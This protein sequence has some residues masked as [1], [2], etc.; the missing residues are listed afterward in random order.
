MHIRL[1]RED[2]IPSLVQLA[3][4]VRAVDRWPPHRVG[5]TREF[6]AGSEPLTALVADDEGVVVG[7]VVLH[8]RSA[9][10]V[11]TV[12]SETLGVERSELAVV[13]RLF[14]AP[15]VRGR[16]VGRALL[17]A[18]VDA[19]TGVDRYPILDV[20]TELD[21]AIGLYQAEG[22]TRLGEVAFTFSSPCSPGC[23]HPG[24]SLRSF[25]YSAPGRG[26]VL[27]AAPEPSTS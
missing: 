3:D 24:N 15:Q 12:A 2:D 20:W 18:A 27:S 7:H 23:L 1:R 26:T 16:G 8:Q 4:N 21:A 5:T 13:A 10:T 14:V 9:A 17:R 25:V 6:I 19:A 11:M 22:W